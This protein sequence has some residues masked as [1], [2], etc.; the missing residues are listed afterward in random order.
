MAVDETGVP[1]LIAPLA[2]LMAWARGRS[3]WPLT[4]G[5]ACCAI[6][7]MTC[8]SARYDTD[9]FGIF[10]RGSPRQSDC[11]IVAG[12]I[13]LKMAPRVK[14]LYEQMAAPKYVIAM[15]SCAVSGG[16]FAGG[17]NVVQ[18]VDEI[19]PVD[20][21]LPGLSSSARGALR[22][23]AQADGTQQ[24]RRAQRCREVRAGAALVTMAPDTATDTTAV[25]EGLRG[26]GD[27][28]PLGPGGL[29]CAA[30]TP[31]DLL[32]VMR[33]LKNERG[34]THLA[35]L[36]AV[37]SR[38]D[39][40]GLEM[41]Y[42]VT[43]RADHTMVTIR[44]PLPEDGLSLPSLAD[45]WP[46]AA[47][48]ERE[49]YD[50]FGV[51]FIGHPDLKRIVL[52]DDFIGHPLRKSYEMDPGG[53]SSELVAEAVA[54]PGEAPHNFGPHEGADHDPRLARSPFAEGILPGDPTLHSERLILN[55]GPQHP[56][57]H[58]VLHLWIAFEGEI[59]K[60]AEISHGYLHR[61]IEKLCEYP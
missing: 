52:R 58:G 21:Y 15:G 60:G 35:L 34:F 23:A 42:A 22:R 16:P 39:T 41:I 5:T 25:F 40:G 59:V 6:E 7:M 33:T 20:M 54:T 14:M 47:P 29:P 38:G 28:A 31:T 49:V 12:T 51:R 57:M 30:T 4:F 26:V 2:T 19:I 24:G 56:S 13:N 53:V 48:L 10:Y 27:V 32:H 61:C 43:R 17:Y 3:M 11:M 55:M 36:T 50:L 18:G 1:V 37:D 46:G 9:R 8:G 44:V 45:L